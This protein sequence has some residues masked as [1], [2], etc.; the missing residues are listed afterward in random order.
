M[1]QNGCQRDKQKKKSI[2]GCEGKSVGS[3]PSNNAFLA[4]IAMFDGGDGF[5][6]ITPPQ[7]ENPGTR[8]D[9]IS[10]L[11]QRE[12]EGSFLTGLA[13]GGCP[14]SM[15]PTPQN[16]SGWC[17]PAACA[18]YLFVL[19]RKPTASRYG[20]NS[21]TYSKPRETLGLA[22]NLSVSSSQDPERCVIDGIK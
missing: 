7:P 8:K 1:L 2:S 5:P 10:F 17:K 14:T 16:T 22:I 4:S 12:K 18:P 3:R 20:P 19:D 11:R 6:E 9:P 15:N 21:L 13:A